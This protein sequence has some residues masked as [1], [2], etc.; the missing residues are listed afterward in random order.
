MRKFRQF[1]SAAVITSMGWLLIGCESTEMAS[2][3][4]FEPE[5]YE[6]VAI[7]PVDIS[8]IQQVRP[9][10]APMLARRTSDIAE[11][12]LREKGY[13]VVPVGQSNLAVNMQWWL[14]SGA[15]VMQPMIDAETLL[16]KPR[17]VN[18]ARLELVVT[19]IA[20]NE[21]LW[22]TWSQRAINVNTM[23]GGSVQDAVQWAFNRFPQQAG[24]G[25]ESGS[26]KPRLDGDSPA[27]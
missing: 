26:Q 19:D 7:A 9:G 5:N 21:V 15:D 20:R 6:T 22:R 27:M 18:E 10:S 1:F 2:T 4:A 16:E 13:T 14:F 11:S 3:P 23:T 17:D 25:T 8:A 24:A 12:I